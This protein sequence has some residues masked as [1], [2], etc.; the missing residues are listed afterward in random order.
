MEDSSIKNKRIAKNTLILYARTFLT[1][2]ISLYTSRITLQALGIDNYGVYNVVG[3]V[4]SMFSIISGPIYTSISRFLTY[5]I[6]KGN[7]DEQRTIFATSVNVLLCIGICLTIIGE[8]IGLWALNYK[9]NIPE[10]NLN[11]AHWVLQCSIFSMALGFVNVP[12]WSSIVA[13]EK[14]NVYAY[15]SIADVLLKLGLSFLILFIQHDVLKLYA[16]GIL[17]IFIL[18]RIIY[19]FYCSQKFPECK[20]SFVIDRR[21]SKKMMSFA[22]WSFLGNGTYLINTQGISI[23]MNLFWGVVVNA[24]RGIAS[25]IEG[26]AMT[27]V[28]SFTTAFAPQII[29]SFAE[30]DLNYMYSLMARGAKFSYFLMLIILLP[31]EFE[32]SFILNLWL[33]EVPEFTVAFVR[34]SLICT[35]LLIFGNSYVQGINAHGDIRN[36]QISVTIVGLTVFP[37]TWILYRIGFSVSCFYY[38]S[39]SAYF[40]IIWIRM[41]FVQKLLGYRI[42]SFIK[43]VFSPTVFSTILSLIVPLI[44]INSLEEGISRFIILTVSTILWTSISVICVGLNQKERQI[45]L[46][47]YNRLLT[48]FSLKS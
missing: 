16:V 46:K 9:L 35:T 42:G 14:M 19:G 11:S 20:Y 32:T 31:M 1:L 7:I 17:L 5:G 2:I 4:V 25:Q 36:Y 8:F 24:A 40:I 48:K 39:I 33:T 43:D 22:V 10:E 44:I 30:S 6:G 15:M 21:L 27:F 47:I 26:A 45:P 18:D 29:K 13:H 3:G 28:N 38:I 12:Y 23:L 41:W 37:I 34:L